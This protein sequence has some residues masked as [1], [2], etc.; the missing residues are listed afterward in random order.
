MGAGIV[1]TFRYSKLFDVA[2]LTNRLGK[3]YSA[4]L[5]HENRATWERDGIYVQVVR[6]R[7]LLLSKGQIIEGKLSQRVKGTGQQGCPELDGVLASK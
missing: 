1:R 7:R 5:Q 2:A 6:N 4:A 3:R